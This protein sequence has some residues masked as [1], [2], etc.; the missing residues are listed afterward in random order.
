MKGASE[1]GLSSFQKEVAVPSKKAMDKP[2]VIGLLGVGLDDKD[3]HKRVTKSDDFV[4][5]GG[6][7]KTHEQMQD[8]ALRFQES[9]QN[10][11]K[12]LQDASQDEVR[13]L[14]VKAMDRDDG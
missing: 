6:S 11:G 9:L 5:I 12:R 2:Q 13:E 4:L 3:G 8:V 1:L 10:R 14:L 7:E